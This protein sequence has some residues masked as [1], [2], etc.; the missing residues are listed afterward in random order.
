MKEEEESPLAELLRA[1]L[2]QE[3]AIP[4]WR[5]M[6]LALYHPRHGYYAQSP[7]R[8]I[9]RRGDYYTGP[10]S[11][12]A[13]GRLFSEAVAEAWVLLG[14]PAI[15]DLWEQGAG[16]GWLACDLIG[17][18]RQREPGLAERIRYTI[19]E[20]RELPRK[21]QEER[22]AAAGLSDHFRWVG[23]WDTT[24]KLVGVFFSNELVDSFPVHR[25]VRR[26]SGWSES[27][28]TG[29]EGRFCFAERPLPRGSQWQAV[30]DESVADLPEGWVVEASLGAPSWMRQVGNLI[31]RGLVFTF[32]YGLLP[33]ERFLSG[34]AAGTLRAY[35]R[36]R[37]EE[38]LLAH[39]GEQDLTAHVDFGALRSAGEETGL[40]TLALVDQHHF[41]VGILSALAERSEG[42]LPEGLT[43]GGFQT[44]THPD[45]L[46][47]THR[48]LI[49]S[50]GI[51]DASSLSCL[52]FARSVG[53]CPPGHLP[54]TN[55]ACTSIAPNGSSGF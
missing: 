32:D 29:K 41:F 42:R 23:S 55:R 11:S 5:F 19:V 18:L 44:L 30:L 16:A 25:L 36:H 4:F 6:E 22:V 21:E 28:V 1:L 12:P 49:Q 9:G 17:S 24:E 8:R 26:A 40:C 46:G 34:R 27:F 14:R 15:L 37:R 39:P 53:S 10:S 48:V 20:P 50:K 52:R 47:R 2:A 35:R 13:F 51:A 38:D 43:P 3:G 45:F 7:S 31:D 54:A 33:Q